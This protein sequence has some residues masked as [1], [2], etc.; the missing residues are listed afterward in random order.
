MTRIERSGFRW[1][2]AHVLMEHK[3][4]CKNNHGHNYRASIVLEGPVDALTGMVADFYVLEQIQGWIDAYWDHGTI[5][6][7]NDSERLQV[8]RE[9]LSDKVWVMPSERSE[10]TAENLAAVLLEESTRLVR[11]ASPGVTV[12]QIT[13]W[14]T[15][16]LSATVLA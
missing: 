7:P 4:K 13:V 6:N 5:L 9:F 12:V 16:D 11:L 15:D 10:P 14:E 1:S 3:G 8:H 2:A